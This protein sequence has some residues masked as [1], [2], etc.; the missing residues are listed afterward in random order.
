M[1]KIWSWIV[2]EVHTVESIVDNL[3]TTVEK[4]EAHALNKWDEVFH[5]SDVIDKAAALRDAAKEE[6]R[7]AEVVADNI[8]A[9]LNTDVATVKS[10]V[11]EVATEVKA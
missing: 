6:A 9:L 1:K 8:G 7:K 2:G 11:A 4:L 10:Q 3:R 5:H